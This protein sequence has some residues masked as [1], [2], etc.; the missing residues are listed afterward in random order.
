MTIHDFDIARFF[1][2]DLVEVHAYGANAFSD[3][4][5]DAGDFDSAIVT[6]R[7]SNDELM[8]VSCSR[9]PISP[10]ATRRRMAA[11]LASKTSIEPD[12]QWS[13]RFHQFGGAGS[14]PGQVE[15]E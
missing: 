8:M 15:V 7:G 13:R 4:T 11:K 6:M 14:D 9:R 12:H 5:R 2:P 10:S 1:V 3:Y